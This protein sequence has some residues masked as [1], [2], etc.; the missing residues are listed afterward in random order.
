M[1]YFS[2]IIQLWIII[3]LLKITFLHKN[4]LDVEYNLIEFIDTERKS[5]LI[6]IKLKEK[7]PSFVG[8]IWYIIFTILTLSSLYKL[9]IYLICINKS[10]TIKKIISNSVDLSKN[11]TYNVYNPIFIYGDKIFTYK[12]SDNTAENANPTSS[13]NT[14]KDLPI[15]ENELFVNNNNN[16]N[17]DEKDFAHEQGSIKGIFTNVEKNGCLSSDIINMK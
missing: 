13:N 8:Y 15:K 7:E 11:S 3:I 17:V 16:I 1:R 10:V 5:N 4:K 6:I 14:K 2:K 12:F 9:Y